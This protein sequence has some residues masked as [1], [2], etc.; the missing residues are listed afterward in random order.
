LGHARQWPA[1]VDV[2]PQAHELERSHVAAVAAIEG[3]LRMKG[4]N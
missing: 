3:S 4:P 1:S 2:L